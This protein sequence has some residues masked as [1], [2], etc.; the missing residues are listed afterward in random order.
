[1]RA[2]GGSGQE[3]GYVAGGGSGRR[4]RTQGFGRGAAGRNQSGAAAAVVVSRGWVILG[5]A[6]ASMRGGQ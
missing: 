1:M 3:P 4:S 5:Y 2:H 6:F